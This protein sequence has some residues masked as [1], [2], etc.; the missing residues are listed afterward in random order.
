[1]STFKPTEDQ[2][3]A[4]YLRETDPVLSRQIRDYLAAHPDEAERLDEYH[5]V[6]SS[7]RSFELESP[8]DDVLARVS[9][10]A[11]VHLKKSL[12]QS[13]SEVLF[14]RQRVAY[15]L[16]AVLVLAIGFSIHDMNQGVQPQFAAVTKTAN[17]SGSGTSPDGTVMAT[18]K[19][20]DTNAGTGSLT[21]SLPTGG[22]TAEE[23]REV[24]LK[25]AQA[26]D[27][28]TKG[29]FVEASQIFEQV[30]KKHPRFDLRIE[31][32]SNWIQCLDKMGQ[33]D[34]AKLRRQELAKILQETKN[35]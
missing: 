17:N 19:A 27:L 12:W 10:Q 11:R 16:A 8:S 6:V 2:V 32:Y 3:F 14:A 13:V 29:L 1:M 28:M 35:L 18:H 30:I 21:G 34:N 26:K 33:V 15:G 23:L 5:R 20:G 7:F 24:N 9:A 31:L 22:L 4:Y 25:Y